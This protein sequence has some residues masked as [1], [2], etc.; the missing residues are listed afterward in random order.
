[1][2]RLRGVSKAF[3]RRTVLEG[4]D[5]DVHAGRVTAVLG[6]NGSGKTTLIRMVLGLVR[7]DAGTIEVDGRVLDG[8]PSYR[9]RIGYMPQAP[10]F[11]ENLTGR[12]ILAMLES[13]RG[14][15]ARD[16]SLIEAFALA[17]EL[18]KP[19]RTLSGGT[20]QKVS[21]AAAFLFEPALLI[22]DEPG[23]GL[24]PLAN[25]ALKD[26]IRRARDEGRTA[27]LTSHVLS[28][29]EQLADDVVVLHE[30]RV[31]WAGSLGELRT[32]THETSLERAVT[33]LMLGRELPGEAA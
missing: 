3:R 24:D 17:P 30:G 23:A 22:L 26:A 21:A 7:P 8:D 33:K 25:A 12:E 16:R 9:A 13:L 2:I 5:L 1:M 32:W 29:V 19:V 6:P 11:P 27:V 14:P 4:I 10:R 18:D 28:E 20:R 31:L 15:G